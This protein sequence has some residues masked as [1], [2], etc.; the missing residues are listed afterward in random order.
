MDISV[1][2]GGVGR[3]ARH[4]SDVRMTLAHRVS[5][6]YSHESAL[7]RHWFKGDVAVQFGRLLISSAG[8]VL[9]EL[10]IPSSGPSGLLCVE[11]PTPACLELVFDAQWCTRQ[12]C[13]KWELRLYT[14]DAERVARYLGWDARSA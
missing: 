2:E 9:M 8:V 10:E 3:Y 14:P 7:V 13:G 12:L 4:L 11:V 1:V 6:P 5:L